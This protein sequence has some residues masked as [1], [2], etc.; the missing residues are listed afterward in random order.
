MLASQGLFVPY[1]PTLSWR[2]PKP[3]KCRASKGTGRA[4]FTAL[5][6]TPHHQLGPT[7]PRSEALSDEFQDLGGLAV[8]L[9]GRFADRF[10]LREYGPGD[11]L[12]QQCSNRL[13][14][15]D[16]AL[17]HQNPKGHDGGAQ[18]RHCIR[19]VLVV[20]HFATFS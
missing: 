9:G 20:F 6:L 14:A 7:R 17:L 4:R 13:I 12:I 2:W 10:G 1:G 18:R 19:T 16:E 8:H 11:R 15:G 3:G 5:W